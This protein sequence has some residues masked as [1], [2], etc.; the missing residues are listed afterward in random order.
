[1]VPGIFFEPGRGVTESSSRF[2]AI[3]LSRA[4][5]ILRLQQSVTGDGTT[6]T[7][8]PQR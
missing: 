1:V 7:T 3:T 5:R 6:I 4:R 2:F 8:V